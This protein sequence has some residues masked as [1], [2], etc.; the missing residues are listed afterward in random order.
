MNVDIIELEANYILWRYKG[1]DGASTINADG[2]VEKTE[3]CEYDGFTLSPDV[4]SKIQLHLQRW[5]NSDEPLIDYIYKHAQEDG[6][7]WHDV[8]SDAMKIII[9][10]VRDW[11]ARYNP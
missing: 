3:L 11:D 9:D 1:H 8:P 5:L 4:T 6:W 2:W 7:C 10:R